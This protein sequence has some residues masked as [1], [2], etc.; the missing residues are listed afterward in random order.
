MIEFKQ[1]N[2][3]N[4]ALCRGMR[5]NIFFPDTAVG[6]SVA[7]IYDQAVKICERCPVADKCLAYAMEC[8]TNDVEGTVC[9]VARLRES[10]STVVMVVRAVS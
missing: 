6:V 9:G 7:G 4:K 2:W 3:F 8:E 10:V 1:L 5:T